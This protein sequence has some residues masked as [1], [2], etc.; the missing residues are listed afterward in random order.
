MLTKLNLSTGLY[1]FIT[2]EG[3]EQLNG[4]TE[5]NTSFSGITF[6]GYF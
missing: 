2:E 4:W 1:K 6:D 5:K 3:E